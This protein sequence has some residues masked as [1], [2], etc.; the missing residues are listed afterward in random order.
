MAGARDASATPRCEGKLSRLEIDVSQEQSLRLLREKKYAEIQA[1]MDGFLSKYLTGHF[2]DEE[3][4]FEFEAF[5]HGGQML[6]PLFQEWVARFPRSYA[7]HHGMAV[8]LS[9]VAWRSRGEKFVNE[10]SAEQFEQFDKEIK[11][12]QSWAMRGLELSKKPI[13]SY[14]L[15]LDNAVAINEARPYSDRILSKSLLVQPDNV[16]VR[17]SYARL[18][19]PMWGG[20]HMELEQFASSASHPG[21]APDKLAAVA[22]TVRISI[23][24]DHWRR[25]QY[26]RAVEQYERASR[27]CRLNEPWIQIGEIRLVQERYSDALASAE[28]AIKMVP[29]SP[30]G[31]AVK[32]RA[33]HALGRQAEALPL[34][35]KLAPQGNRFVL[36]LLGEYYAFGYGGAKRDHTEA[37]RFFFLAAQAGDKR[38]AWFLEHESK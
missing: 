33:L 8:H 25:K 4:R 12:S 31:R 7:A 27:L 38:A 28:N 29:D 32:A 34:L 21:L 14:Q 6:T 3:L 18:L 36:C 16:I 15:L 11:N 2:T 5:N 22:Y 24:E 23:A 9:A 10:T 30:Q 26:D 19:T 13:L 17:Q 37:K 1:R 20:S 35:T